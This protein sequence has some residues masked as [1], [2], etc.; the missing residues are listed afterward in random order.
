MKRKSPLLFITTAVL[1]LL[2]ADST[3]AAVQD[4]D[5]VSGVTS[6]SVQINYNPSNDYPGQFWGLDKICVYLDETPID[7]YQKKIVV[8]G[9]D[10]PFS[11]SVD[12]Y[13]ESGCASDSNNSTFS[14]V[15]GFQSIDFSLNTALIANGDHI[16]SVVLV[17]YDGLEAPTN[18]NFTTYNTKFYPP[19][20]SFNSEIFDCYDC[21]AIGV[22]YLL[23]WT[24]GTSAS[25]NPTEVSSSLK[26]N[27]KWGSWTKAGRK[28]DKYTT[29]ITLPGKTWIQVRAKWGGK[30]YYYKQLLNPGYTFVVS[31]PS[32]VRVGSTGRAK[33]RLPG[34]KNSRCV[35]IEKFYGDYGHS[36]QKSYGANMYGGSLTF[37]RSNQYS[38]TLDVTIE[39][40]IPGSTITGGLGWDV[41]YW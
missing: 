17:D 1:S 37:S 21:L 34:V 31:G 32:N 38:G 8:E 33:V 25:G 12:L 15:S 30:Y 27:N 24:F 5:T 11:S 4:G 3:Y 29:K 28:N 14:W 22:P 16:L 36:Y 10:D 39:C 6:F 2:W 18:L 20:L 41:T 23:S 40:Q 7:S 9:N 19:D 13:P 35:I 26:L